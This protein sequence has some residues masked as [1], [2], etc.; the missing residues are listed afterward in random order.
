[1]GR[2][3]S[4]LLVCSGPGQWGDGARPGLQHFTP[5]GLQ[6]QDTLA[7]LVAW[8]NPFR[9]EVQLLI[10]ELVVEIVATN[11]PRRRHPASRTT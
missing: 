2:P 1:M 8:P 5:R 4:L 3:R 11:G 7:E 6:G 10:R 9:S